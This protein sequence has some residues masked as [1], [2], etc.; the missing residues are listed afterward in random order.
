MERRDLLKFPMV[1]LAAAV[2]LLPPTALLAQ[3]KDPR[4]DPLVETVIKRGKP[5][6]EVVTSSLKG[7][8]EAANDPRALGVLEVDGPGIDAT[9]Q[10]VIVMP[11]AGTVIL[12]IADVRSWR[13]FVLDRQGELLRARE[14]A[15]GKV[16][17]IDLLE[18]I[19]EQELELIFWDKWRRKQN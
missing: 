4:F 9:R 11:A 10:R 16:S 6:E 1:L 19:E 3:A 18:A 8:G 14:S 15:R 2:L 13:I 7:F 12:S 5:L 17:S